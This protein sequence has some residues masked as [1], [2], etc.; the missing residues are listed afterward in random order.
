MFENENKKNGS[1]VAFHREKNAILA[2]H[3]GLIVKQIRYLATLK[4]RTR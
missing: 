4:P 1:K 3:R 2:A